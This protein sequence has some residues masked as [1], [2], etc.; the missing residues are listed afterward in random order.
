VLDS[1]VPEVLHPHYE[2]MLTLV[3][4]LTPNANVIAKIEF[5]TE[6]FI[7]RLNEGTM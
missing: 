5:G 7:T 2:L 6:L 3:A 4:K 1:S